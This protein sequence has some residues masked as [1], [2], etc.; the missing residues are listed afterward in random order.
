M[1]VSVISFAGGTDVHSKLTDDAT[2]FTDVGNVSVED[3]CD[4]QVDPTH[5]CADGAKM[6]TDSNDAEYDIADVLANVTDCNN[7][8]DGADALAEV[9][10]AAPTVTSDMTTPLCR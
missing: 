7:G 2:G 9:T 5:D 1:L 10:D 4:A 6:L 3:S 8:D